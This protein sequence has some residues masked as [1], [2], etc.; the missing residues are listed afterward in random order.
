MKI[1]CK[2][3]YFNGCWIHKGERFNEWSCPNKRCG[4]HVAEEYA[5]CPYCGQKLMF[6]VPVKIKYL[7]NERKGEIIQKADEDCNLKRDH[8]YIQAMEEVAKMYERTAEK[9]GSTGIQQITITIDV[10]GIKDISLL[11]KVI[12]ELKDAHNR[13]DLAA[14]K[15][16]GASGRRPE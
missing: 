1:K 7:T 3:A 10:S 8:R 9:E 6:K 2:P 15:V 5:F 14:S 11:C 12:D 16:G 13:P 4:M